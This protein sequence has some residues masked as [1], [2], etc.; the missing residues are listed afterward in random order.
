MSL[1]VNCE[2]LQEHFD[3]QRKAYDVFTNKYRQADF[4][5]GSLVDLNHL[6]AYKEEVMRK[7]N[8][9]HT[10]YYWFEEQGIPQRQ[11]ALQLAKDTD[12][13]AGTWNTYLATALWFRVDTRSIIAI[14][15]GD[16]TLD[17]YLE[18]CDKN[19]I[20]IQHERATISK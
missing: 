9:A 19:I 4:V 15:L 13:N 12:K 7:W 1:W 2:Y 16:T 10:Y 17:L 8:V 18:W 5:K 6:I 20:R 3:I 11:V 14:G